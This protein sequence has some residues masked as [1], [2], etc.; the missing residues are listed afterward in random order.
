MP[1]QIARIKVMLKGAK[2]TIWRRV[3]VYLKIN[4]SQLHSTIQDV[5]S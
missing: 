2:P 4:L 5:M 1:D 3:D